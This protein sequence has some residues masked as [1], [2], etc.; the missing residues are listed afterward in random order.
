MPLHDLNDRQTGIGA[1]DVSDKNPVSFPPPI[2]NPFPQFRHWT[3]DFRLQT[4]DFRPQTFIT[5]AAIIRRASASPT[6]VSTL[7]RARE[8][9]MAKGVRYAYVGNVPGH[10]GNH[11]Y[12]PGCRKVVIGRDNFFVT[13]M[14]VK[15]RRL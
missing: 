8:I 15:Q 9:A 3:S 7:E 11:T 2:F 13:E 1:A 5:K 6:P 14:H 4:I 10:P 12:C